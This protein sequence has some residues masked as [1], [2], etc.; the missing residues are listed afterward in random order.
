MKLFP[1]PSHFQNRSLR[2]EKVGCIR[3]KLTIHDVSLVNTRHQGPLSYTFPPP[4]TL[5]RLPLLPQYKPP[6]YRLWYR[7]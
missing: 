5:C 6:S 1:H 7:S 3:S 4:L 2:G